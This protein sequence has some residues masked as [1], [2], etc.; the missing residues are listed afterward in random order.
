LADEYYT[1]HSNESGF[2]KIP[3]KCGGSGAR[4][5]VFYDATDR[6][7][8]A[9]V[10]NIRP[11]APYELQCREALAKHQGLK[12]VKVIVQLRE[13]ICISNGQD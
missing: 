5:W 10:E 8:I 7:W 4:G 6:K 1:G 13:L 2:P 12:T 3:S 11:F 9:R